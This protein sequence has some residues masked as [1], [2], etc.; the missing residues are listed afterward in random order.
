MLTI[1]HYPKA[2][3]FLSGRLSSKEK[4][5]LAGGESVFFFL[6]RNRYTK[7]FVLG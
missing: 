6:A 1:F 7:V 3:T 4:K 5:T 2:K